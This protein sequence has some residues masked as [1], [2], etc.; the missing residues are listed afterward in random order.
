VFKAARKH[1]E[2]P[3]K[4]FNWLWLRIFSIATVAGIFQL[5]HLMGLAA[6]SNDFSFN[7]VSILQLGL[8]CS[9]ICGV[10]ELVRAIY[11]MKVS[12]QYNER[13]F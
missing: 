10:S 11:K 3:R 5:G 4:L 8:I 7:S 2:T 6:Y 1:Y 9:G 13:V 12:Y